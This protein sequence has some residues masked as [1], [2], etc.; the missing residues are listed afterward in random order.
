MDA[1]AIF[2]DTAVT[3]EPGGVA[4][5]FGVQKIFRLSDL[6]AVGFA[7]SVEIGFSEIRQLERIAISI[8]PRAEAPE[9]LEA[10][11]EEALHQY[12]VQYDAPL[13]ELGCD[14]VIVSAT[15]RPTTEVLEDGTSKTL[16]F[17][18]SHG[19]V[20]RMPRG[21]E[22]PPEVEKMDAR[23]V[24]IGSGA[25]EPSYVEVFKQKAARTLHDLMGSRSG[26]IISKAMLAHQLVTT[27]LLVAVQRKPVEGVSANFLG[28]VMGRDG[29]D[30]NNVTHVFR[31]GEHEEISTPPLATSM[32]E[33]DALEKQ[34]GLPASPGI[35]MA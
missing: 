8:G 34:H 30:M 29:W 5:A 35:A 31:D 1:A 10:W 32:S 9:I 21:D 24:S 23:G 20:V 25:V 3:Y 4:V 13:R 11:H 12:R 26:D 7:G 14:F 27:A 6:A 16:P 18:F 15:D 22:E 19:F 17:Y 33:L 28:A 2:G